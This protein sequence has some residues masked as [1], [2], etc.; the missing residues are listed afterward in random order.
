MPAEHLK[1]V[2]HILARERRSLSEPHPDREH[3]FRAGATPA[4]GP[5][6]ATSAPSSLSGGPIPANASK[7]SSALQ[8]PG[9]VGAEGCDAPATRLDEQQQHTSAVLSLSESSWSGW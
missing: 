8:T 5:C 7:A 9:S 3:E 6:R 1:R 4:G 2:G